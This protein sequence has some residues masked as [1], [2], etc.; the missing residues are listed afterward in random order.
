MARFEHK[1]EIGFRDVGKSNKLTNKGLL[2]F[3]EDIAGM[4]SNQVGFG[5][6]SIDKTGLTWVLLNWKIRVFSRPLYGES[7]S[8]KTW[9][10]NSVKFYTF[11]DF[12]VYNENGDLVAIATS[13]WVLMDAK[14]MRLTKISDEM[15]S[16]YD[17]ELACV[18]ESEPEIN[19]LN[20]PEEYSTV[21]SYTIQRKDI[22]INRHVHNTYYLDFAY[23]LLPEDIYENSNLDNF[24]ILY[25]KE[26]KLGETLK[27]F[28]TKVENSHYVVMKTEDEKNIHCIVRFDETV[29]E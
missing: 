1:F 27:C 15:I 16:K 10:R 22:D 11:R 4:H 12:E 29:K 5:L 6:N 7:I 8:I 3:L 13:K 2:G 19:K 26:T 24:E 17:P 14:T 25:K 21:L 28:Y 18:F 20:I 9:A 23:E